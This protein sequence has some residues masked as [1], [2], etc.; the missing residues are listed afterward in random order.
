MDHQ[1]GENRF[2]KLLIKI[3]TRESKFLTLIF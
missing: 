3:F 1:G 2:K